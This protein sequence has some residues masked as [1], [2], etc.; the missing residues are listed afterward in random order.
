MEGMVMHSIWNQ[1]KPRRR[2]PV[3]VLMTFVLL[4]GAATWIGATA[5]RQQT[6]SVVITDSG[7]NLSTA[8]VPHGPVRFQVRNDATVPY[9]FE[10]EG[11]DMEHKKKNIAPASD[12][13]TTLDLRAGKY[14]IEAESESGP[15]HEWKAVL[16]AQ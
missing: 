6:V 16:M 7:I 10:V 8:T 9:E 14:E 15:K 1:S 2:L 3:A 12:Y 13:T 4:F 5:A 11:P